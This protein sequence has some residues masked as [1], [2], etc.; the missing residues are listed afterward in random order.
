[1]LWSTRRK[2]TMQLLL[3]F[4]VSLP[5]VAH[6]NSSPSTDTVHPLDAE[7]TTHG[8]QL[9]PA[10][11]TIAACALP[12][13]HDITN[14]TANNSPPSDNAP[15]LLF[16]TNASRHNYE[17]EQIATIDTVTNQPFAINIDDQ[18]WASSSVVYGLLTLNTRNY[19]NDQCYNELRQIYNGIRR[20]EVWA[21]KGQWIHN[22]DCWRQ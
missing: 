15:K 10:L 19:V 12:Y 3:L 7:N 9:T 22:S 21:I 8:G 20:K 5:L 11:G 18:H 6:T 4:V 2:L 1:M 16:S 13:C 14:K 17:S